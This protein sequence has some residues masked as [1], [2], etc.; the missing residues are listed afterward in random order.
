MAPK[1]PA[2][3]FYLFLLDTLYN[4]LRFEHGWVCKCDGIRSYDWVMK[5]FC[6]LISDQLVLSE[7]EG[8][9]SWIACLHQ[10][11]LFR[12]LGDSKQ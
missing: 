1:T 12:G 5:E 10:W 6:R 9:L 11:V 4:L 2:P 7:S 8:M 3:P